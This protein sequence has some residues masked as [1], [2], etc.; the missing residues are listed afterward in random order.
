MRITKLFTFV[1]QAAKSAKGRE[2]SLSPWSKS[3]PSATASRPHSATMSIS[4]TG[5]K[6]AKT[7][8]KA[9]KE[10]QFVVRTASM[11]T[12]CPPFSAQGLLSL[13]PYPWGLQSKHTS[14]SPLSRGLQLAISKPTCQGEPPSLSQDEVISI[15]SQAV[16]SLSPSG[17]LFNYQNREATSQALSRIYSL[18]LMTAQCPSG[19]HWRF[20]EG[21]TGIQSICSCGIPQSTTGGNHAV[22]NMHAW[23]LCCCS[24]F[25]PFPWSSQLFL[26]ELGW[27]PWS[28]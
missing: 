11:T 4:S 12:H 22:S 18:K 16:E 23:T 24:P 1:W 8:K 17:S 3:P 2:A 6:K 9:L 15:P 25:L 13:S 5:A 21:H 19:A 28:T 26:Q 10:E 14:F 20:P 7:P 27:H